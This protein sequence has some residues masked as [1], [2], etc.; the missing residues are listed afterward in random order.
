MAG[1]FSRLLGGGGVEAAWKPLL[2]AL[3]S[4]GHPQIEEA[5]RELLIPKGVIPQ[6][7]IDNLAFLDVQGMEFML[8][9]EA[10]KLDITPSVK[11]FMR[12]MD[13][14][15]QPKWFLAAF[16]DVAQWASDN[17]GAKEDAFNARVFKLLKES[18][19]RE[20]DEA[21]LDR[22]LHGPDGKPSPRFCRMLVEWY[23][24]E[25]GRK[26]ETAMR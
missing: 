15:Q 17:M 23:V 4:A 12:T 9:P 14:P 21:A 18:G 1:F 22:L 11:L 24:E 25:T 7:F 5:A 8:P 13:R 10:G 19:A 2:S 6:R 26:L 16:P 20:D 3:R